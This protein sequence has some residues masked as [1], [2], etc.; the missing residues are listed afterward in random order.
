MM[1]L[2]K[3]SMFGQFKFGIHEH[4]DCQLFFRTFLVSSTSQDILV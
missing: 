3:K 2:V 1:N 4:C